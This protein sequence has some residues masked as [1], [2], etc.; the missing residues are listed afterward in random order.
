MEE[1]NHFLR[2]LMDDLLEFW[3]P[4]GFFSRTFM[5]HHGCITCAAL[6]P[7]VCDILGARQAGG[8]ASHASSL[9]SW[10]DAQTKRERDDLFKAHGVWYSELL[11]LPYW[12]PILFTILDSMHAIF[13]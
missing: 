5:H 6:I 2:P 12:T 4:G 8:F 1:F 3:S 13:L 11:C 7:L 10:R 9:F